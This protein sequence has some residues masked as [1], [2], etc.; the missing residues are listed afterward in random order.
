[1]CR[2]GR[3]SL[4][5]KVL[6]RIGETDMKEEIIVSAD[7]H[8]RG[9]MSIRHADAQ[10]REVEFASACCSRRLNAIREL[11]GRGLATISENVSAVLDWA[12]HCP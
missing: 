4:S 12:S 9:C 10:S 8:I 1:M 6:K 2:E 5:R 3:E 7:L 11:A